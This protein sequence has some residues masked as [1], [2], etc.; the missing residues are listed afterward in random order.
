[1]VTLQSDARSQRLTAFLSGEIDHHSAKTIREEIDLAVSEQIP[2]ELWLDFRDVS[3]MDSS[4]I[5][6]V[7]GRV[8]LMELHGG[9]VSV[10]NPSA[11][12]SKVMRLSGIDRLARLQTAPQSVMAAAESNTGGESV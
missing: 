1:M 10:C 12:I 11:H 3:F 2:K 7:M 8:R 4:G 9:Q 5:G 6:L